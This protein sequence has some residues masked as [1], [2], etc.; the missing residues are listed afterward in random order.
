MQILVFRF[1]DPAC[2]LAF[3]F[4]S[5]DPPSAELKTLLQL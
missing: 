1:R 2:R 3:P 5:F 4:S